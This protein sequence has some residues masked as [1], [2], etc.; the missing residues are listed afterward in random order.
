MASYGNAE[1]PTTD[2]DSCLNANSGGGSIQMVD[3]D[4]ELEFH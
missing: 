3:Q 1:F 4:N 2:T